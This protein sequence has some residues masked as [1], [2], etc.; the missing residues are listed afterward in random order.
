MH[1]ANSSR[2]LTLRIAD[3]YDYIFMTLSMQHG[4]H[5]LANSPAYSRSDQKNDHSLV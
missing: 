2:V 5:L 3:A 4:L 1:V